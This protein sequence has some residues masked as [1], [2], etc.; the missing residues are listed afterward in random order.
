MGGR[1]S[2]ISTMPWCRSWIKVQT[3]A[4]SS[5]NQYRSTR[6]GLMRIRDVEEGAI[7]PTIDANAVS[8]R[9]SLPWR[10]RRNGLE[11]CKFAQ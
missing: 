3:V 5:H 8:T 10:N 4:H 11:H 1:D 9:N 6:R 7:S 2:G